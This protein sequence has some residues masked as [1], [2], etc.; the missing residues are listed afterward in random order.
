MAIK[1][2]L[3]KYENGNISIMVLIFMIILCIFM[4]VIFDF[5]N[6]FIKREKT[7]N[8]AEM[9]SLAVSQELLCLK[10]NNIDISDILGNEYENIKDYEINI[11]IDYDEVIVTAKTPLNLV[12]VNKLLKKN[13]I[14]STSVSKII[15]PWSM[16]FSFCKR[17]KFNF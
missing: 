9:L 6:I 4:L 3:N 1:P 10:N 5:S 2:N 17:Y 8:I 11:Q 16:D 7:E 13:S 14:S 15:Y 12:L